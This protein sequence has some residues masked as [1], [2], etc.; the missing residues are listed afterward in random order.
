VIPRA[1]DA[2][3]GR[4]EFRVF[5]EDYPTPDGTC[6]RDYVHVNDL[7]SAHLLA[8]DALRDGRP[9]SAY[10]L[11][12]GRPTSVRD[13]LA[14]VQRVTGRPVP[15][16]RAPRREGDPAAL[17]AASDRARQELGWTPQFE[18]LDIIVKTAWQWREAHPQGY[19]T[20]T[21]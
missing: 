13:V 21:R 8:L 12:N 14:S 6:L 20:E 2:S 9:S 7:A 19:A 17:Y 11:G 3:M 15:Y 5:G 1:L 10:N 4:G 18:D 16:Q